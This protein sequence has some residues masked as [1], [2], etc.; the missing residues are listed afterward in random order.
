MAAAKA[1]FRV[2]GLDNNSK[3]VANLNNFISSIEGVD[4]DELKEIGSTGAYF[5]TEDF[6]FI[7]V[8]SAA[9]TVLKSLQ[10]IASPFSLTF[11]SNN[12]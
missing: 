1:G 10:V 8:P 11:A 12:L 4:S 7:I 3:K 2:I 6:I 9:V 5:A